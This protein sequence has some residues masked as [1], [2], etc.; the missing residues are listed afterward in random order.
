[1]T[2][3]D[4]LQ[5]YLTMGGL[6]SDIFGVV[7]VGNYWIK[8]AGN[9]LQGLLETQTKLNFKW[10]EQAQK[11]KAE[12]SSLKASNASWWRLFVAEFDLAL[13][14]MNARVYQSRVNIDRSREGFSPLSVLSDDDFWDIE[15]IRQHSEQ[16]RI[17][18]KEV[19]AEATP[20]SWIPRWGFRLIVAGF[21]LQ[22]LGALPI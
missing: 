14:R 18:L 22:F 11:K 17:R 7:I 10:A 8:Y 21:A 1:M 15:A 4:V 12:L 20:K 3:I 9:T 13:R 19:I 16:M 5:S 6:L 2:W